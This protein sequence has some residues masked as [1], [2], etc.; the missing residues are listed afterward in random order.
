MNT[1]NWYKKQ[2]SN[3]N[4]IISQEKCIEDMIEYYEEYLED[5]SKTGS[6]LDDKQKKILTDNL[7][8]ISDALNRAKN[9]IKGFKLEGEDLKRIVAD[10]VFGELGDKKSKGRN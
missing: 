1:A 10:L 7:I 6:P 5:L 4:S 9:L 2:F 8:K 3:K